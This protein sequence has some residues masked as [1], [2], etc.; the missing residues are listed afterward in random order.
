MRMP[1]LPSCFLTLPPPNRLSEED[2]MRCLRQW[3]CFAMI[4]ITTNALMQWQSAAQT[5]RTLSQLADE[6]MA[7]ACARAVEDEV[8][9]SGGF[10][11]DQA[12]KMA[13]FCAIAMGKWG[14]EE[15]NYSSDIDVVFMHNATNQACQPLPAQ[16]TPPAETLANTHPFWLAWQQ[17]T[18]VQAP[19]DQALAQNK[20]DA[21]ASTTQKTGEALCQAIAR[22]VVRL[23][24][25]HTTEGQVFR[26][27]SDLRPLGKGGPLACSLG[28]A[29]HYYHHQGRE[30]ERLALLKA[31]VVCAPPAL[32]HTFETLRTQFVYR[33]YSDWGMLEGAALIKADIDRN[34]KNHQT[35][36]KLGQ[37]GIRE[38][39]F[40]VQAQQL[41]HG[42][43]H[44][45]LRTTNHQQALQT[46]QTLQLAPAALVEQASL[47]YWHLRLM[48]ARVQM[49]HAKQTHRLPTDA[50]SLYG[51]LHPMP[52]LNAPTEAART[53]PQQQQIQGLQHLQSTQTATSQRFISLFGD[54][55]ELQSMRHAP[56]QETWREMWQTKVG[57]EGRRAKLGAKLAVAEGSEGKSSEQSGSEGKSGS[58]SKSSEQNG[59]GSGS[60]SSEQNGSGSRSE[61]K[62]SEQNGSG[63]KSSEQNGS[64]SGSK[65][66]EQNGSGKKEETAQRRGKGLP[67]TARQQSSLHQADRLFQDLMNSREGER[68]TAKLAHI[69]NQPPVY[70]HGQGVLQHWLALLEGFGSRNALYTMLA[71]QPKM[72]AWVGRI[73]QDGGAYANVLQR[74][75][76]F[77]ESFMSLAQADQRVHARLTDLAQEHNQEQ[78]FLLAI[79]EAHAHGVLQALNTYLNHLK[80][81]FANPTSTSPKQP[82]LPLSAHRS[83]LSQLADATI[84]ASTQFCRRQ[85]TERSASPNTPPSTQGF[86]VLAM[87]KLGS[88]E[89]RFGSDLDLVFV[90]D[91]Q[92]EPASGSEASVFYR[93][94]AQRI[95]NLLTA[96]THLGKL[97]QLDHRLR[98]FGTRSVLVPS[99]QN[100][101]GFLQ[102]SASGHAEMWN[103]MA[104]TRMRPVAGDL[105]LGKA[106]LHEVDTAWQQFPIT[107]G[108]IATQ[109]QQIAL[110]LSAANQALHA[111]KD[112][113]LKHHPGAMIAFEFLRQTQILQAFKQQRGWQIPPDSSLVASLRP[114]YRLL[115][116]NRRM[117]EGTRP[118]CRPSL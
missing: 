16:F 77:L 92:A 65:S 81:L 85:L 2:W 22:R 117:A 107:Q 91:G 6:A 46:L 103:F 32:A 36:L 88:S 93:K 9:R 98:P 10:P 8:Q 68:C 96:P 44:P 48:E 7:L 47:D 17:A 113:H 116:E 97:Y 102:G 34:A 37:G 70:A 104:F 72:V 90:H 108:D 19:P 29:H 111:R 109:A 114:G 62:S 50:L 63:G 118:A 99:L 51:V 43:R 55:Q 60:K 110:R 45:S 38:N 13:G 24:N 95:S 105:A 58:G 112:V 5:C 101:R 26:V 42:G 86:C 100:Y 35:D 74:H 40:W 27:D 31:R 59:S 56:W 87:G 39:E 64:G 80:V 61:G 12:G 25:A 14:G 66:S 11:V 75:P 30:W 49:L 76:Q 106:L 73:F 57:P 18:Q 83:M 71:A 3:R 67:N 115:A 23:L 33:Q 69:L 82:N 78:S 53:T 28:F 84:Q 20:P 15:L 1:P 41:V 89:L 94:L 4:R 52:R 54:I 79:Q 21:S